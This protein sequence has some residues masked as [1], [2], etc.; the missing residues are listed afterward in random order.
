[1][2]KLLSV[3]MIFLLLICFCACTEQEDTSAR[4]IIS[5]DGIEGEIS[6]SVMQ[7]REWEEFTSGEYSLINNWPTKKFAL[8]AGVPLEAVLRKAGVWDSF[9]SVTIAAADGYNYTFT[10]SQILEERYYYPGLMEDDE[11]GKELRPFM[12]CFDY[13]ESSLDEADLETLEVP[14]LVFGQGYI[15]EHNSVAFVEN[16]AYI[17]VSASSPAQL[18]APSSFPATGEITAGDTVKL[19]HDRI[20]LIKI[21]Y[22]TDGS[23]PDYNSAMYN[24]STYQPDLN[25]PIKIEEDT[26]IKAF[27]SG[28]GYQDSE[29]VSFEFT[30]K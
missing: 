14:R 4:V 27:A 30:V 18:E 10:R 25:V 29:I 8:A 17:T 23:D 9:Q 3:L 22:T 12:L 11:E 7:M 13:A 26:V 1:M 19:T 24:P 5:G 21:F 16:V 2:K 20:G 6:F 15:N 28:Y